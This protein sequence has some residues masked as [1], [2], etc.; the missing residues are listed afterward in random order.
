MQWL[1][2]YNSLQSQT[3]TQAKCKTHLTGASNAGRYEKMT[4]FDQYLALSHK[5]LLKASRD[6]KTKELIIF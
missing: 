5:W 4:I 6:D 2:R 1:K 3:I